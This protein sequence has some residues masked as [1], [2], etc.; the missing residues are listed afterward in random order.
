MESKKI[1]QETQQ[2]RGRVID[3]TNRGLPE[4]GGW[5]EKRNG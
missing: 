5:G 2:N 1:T 3:R 4:V